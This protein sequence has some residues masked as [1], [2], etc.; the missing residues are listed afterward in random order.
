MTVIA[1]AL[2]ASL[3]FALCAPGAMA[4]EV[5]ARHVRAASAE[6]VR[7]WEAAVSRMMSD[8]SLR[9]R[10]VREDTMIAG[11][12]H[13]RLAQFHDGVPVFGGE[14]VV[15]TESGRVRTVFGTLYEGLALDVRPALGAETALTVAE[16][17]GF[18]PVGSEGGPE[19]VVLPGDHGAVLAY[20]MR[21]K[22]I[23][24]VQINMLFVDAMSGAIA[25]EYNDLKSQAVGRGT[26][27]LNDEKKVST[28]AEG[29]GFVAD[30]RLRP[31]AISTFDF[32]GDVFRFLNNSYLVPFPNDLASDSD[33]VWTDGATVDAHAY[34]GYTYDYYF[35]RF[36][37]RGLDNAN[38][39]IRIITHPA[40]RDEVFRFPN[41]LFPELYCNAFY[42]GDGLIV[43]GEGLPFPVGG[44]TCDYLAGALDVV[45]HELTHGVTDYSSRLIYRNES[46]A[47]NEAF[48]DIMGTAVE[49]FHQP[50]GDGPLRADYENGEDVLRPG[51][52]RSMRNPSVWGDPDHY[53]IRYTGTQDGGGVH[54]NSGIANHAY[55]LA[56]EGGTH[57]LSGLSVQ[58]VGT[59]NREQMERVFYRAFTQLLTPS[60]NF[61][62]ARA[63]TIQAAR[64]LFGANSAPERAVTQAWTAVG[65]N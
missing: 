11:R 62:Q 3:A 4:A 56:I 17:R 51:G 45:A 8:G 61:A 41:S 49:F 57:R 2:A 38:L 47:L 42:S 37:R 22:A 21:A 25:L 5:E 34:V 59:A 9:V 30:D 27:V 33:N 10:Q 31:P 52:I 64:D 12:E 43:L 65:V 54:I 32:K 28:R 48:S 58:G 36:G 55:F 20:R 19:L 14:L 39:P 44:Q 26:G 13:A 18:A 1:R 16:S 46:G 53:S 24:G 50:P 7:Q 35:R 40:R 6:E 60:A 15:Q 29:G 23:Q 63:A